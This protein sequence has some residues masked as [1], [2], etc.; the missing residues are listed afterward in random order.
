MN[1]WNQVETPREGYLALNLSPLLALPQMLLA[2]LLKVHPLEKDLWT[3]HSLSPKQHL[4]WE[5][6]GLFQDFQ[7][8]DQVSFAFMFLSGLG[9]SDFFPVVILLAKLCKNGSFC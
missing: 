9:T 7:G 8:R 3:L 2:V 4:W 6:K 1:L 5:E